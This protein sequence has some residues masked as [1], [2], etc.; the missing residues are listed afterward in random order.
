MGFYRNYFS[1]EI[2][3]NSF[4]AIGAFSGSHLYVHLTADLE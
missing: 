2:L 1:L 4:F 3:R